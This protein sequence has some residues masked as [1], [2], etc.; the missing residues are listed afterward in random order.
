MSDL[1]SITTRRLRLS[2]TGALL[3][4]I[5]GVTYA[6]HVVWLYRFRF[7]YDTD[8]DESGYMARGLNDAHA[9]LSGGPLK[10]LWEYEKQGVEAPLVSLLNVPINSVFGLGVFQSLMLLPVLAALL[11]LVT[12]ALARQIVSPRWALVAA[13]V[14]AAMPAVADYSRQFVFAVPAALFFTATVWA[15]LRSERLHNARWVWLAGVFTG[16]LVLSRTMTVSFLPGIAVIGLGQLFAERAERKQRALRLLVGAG[17]ATFVAASWFLHNWRGVVDYLRSSGYGSAAGQG[18]FAHS[19]GIASWAYWVKETGLMLNE[20]YLPLGVVLGCCF[21]AALAMRLAARAGRPGWDV[22][23]LGSA[24]FALTV[25][26][27]EGYLSLT[28]SSNEGTGFAIP[29]LPALVILAVA[30]VARL[31]QRPL[32]LALGAALVAVSLANLAMKSGSG[33]A[34]A[35]VRTTHVPSV[36]DVTVTDG[37]G[38]IQWAVGLMGYKVGSPDSKLPALDRKWLPFS[39]VFVGWITRY[40]AAHHERAYI[41][42]PTNHQFVSQ[43]WISLANSLWH[44]ADTYEIWPGPADPNE[45]VAE[46]R[47]LLKS[48]PANLIETTS[49]A[50]PVATTLF[51]ASRVEAAA[52]SLGYRKVKTF[53]MPDGYLLRF[54]WKSSPLERI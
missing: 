14:V 31:E 17:I 4:A 32:Q 25:A 33:G 18:Q 44:H 36:G 42:T 54:W 51:E 46:Y 29:L 53:R 2:P 5:V 27:V 50:G 47:A 7:G 26:V 19:H 16:C 13:L 8:W 34:L 41:L 28:S 45:T 40:A 38:E 1:R 6:L 37:R 30:V 39:R 3:A 10:L 20:T 21:L 23:T 52:R 35:T 12:F 49:K 22:A 43:T 48:Y 9:F 15:L 11:T 24:G